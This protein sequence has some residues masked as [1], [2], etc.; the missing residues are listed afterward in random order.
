MEPPPLGGVSVAKRVCT[1]V[2]GW[3]VCVGVCVYVCVCCVCVG[4]FVG[5][6][7]VYGGVQE[8]TLPTPAPC[9]RQVWNS[10]TIHQ[11]T[12]SI[13]STPPSATRNRFRPFG[14]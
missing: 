1:G 12:V 13:P 6:C 11:N 2:L 14:K 5:V 4:L 3:T 10:G 7:V 8:Q 9:D